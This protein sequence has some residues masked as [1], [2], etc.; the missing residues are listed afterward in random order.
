MSVGGK[1]IEKVPKTLEDGRHVIRYWVVDEYRPGW[2]DE[3]C[4]YA[5]PSESEPR[6]G[7]EIWW[8][9]GKIY[10][11]ADKQQLTKVGYSFNPPAK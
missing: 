1:I 11:D 5:E 9:A 6:L 10:F 8:Q 7:D 4:V 3:T 2:F